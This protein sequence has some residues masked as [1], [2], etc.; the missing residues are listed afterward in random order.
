M[1]T[2]Y[3]WAVDQAEHDPDVRVIVVTGAGRGFCAGADA[4]ALSGH[5]DRG[6]Y[7]AGHRPT[8]SPPPATACRPELDHDFAFH[9]GLTTPVIAAINGP[10]AGVGLVLACYCDLR[11]AARRREAH[12]RAR[13]AQPAGRVRPVVAAAPT[14]RPGP[15]QRPAA[16]EPG[17]PRRGGRGHRPGER[18]RR[19]P[20]S[21]S[22]T[23]TPTPRMLATTVSRGLAR[24]HQAPDRPRPA[25][26]P[27]RLGRPSPPCASTP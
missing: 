2:E 7:D 9:F 11:F 15:G 19:P 22:P 14:D 27:G 20:T 10:A 4:A 23:P 12:D 6:G 13:A 21:C 5:V 18:G 16:V 24:R 3:R 26:R 1:H 17:R 8:T 25:P